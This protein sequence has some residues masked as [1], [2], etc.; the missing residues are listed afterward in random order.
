MSQMNLPSNGTSRLLRSSCQPLPCFHKR[1]SQREGD[2]Q[3][4][5]ALLTGNSADLL[6]VRTVSYPV[7]RDGVVVMEQQEIQAIL[8]SLV[9]DFPMRSK[10]TLWRGQTGKVNGGWCMCVTK[11][12]HQG[13][14]V[15]CM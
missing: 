9:A 2:S 11:Q 1:V 14:K 4:G 5:K 15:R 6:E 12:K 7:R 10:L 13:A 8:T 3:R